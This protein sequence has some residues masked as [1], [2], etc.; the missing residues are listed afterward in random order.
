MQLN[1]S[2]YNSLFKAT[3]VDDDQWTASLRDPRTLIGAPFDPTPHLYPR[4]L[5][6]KFRVELSTTRKKLMKTIGYILSD[7]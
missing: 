1:H 2:R 5:Q 3:C 4:V 6:L 7:I